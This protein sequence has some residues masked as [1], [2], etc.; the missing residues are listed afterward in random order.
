MIMATN[1]LFLNLFFQ[2][3]FRSLPG[4]VIIALTTM[5]LPMSIDVSEVFLCK[6]LF[7]AHFK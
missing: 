6:H 7:H 1:F 4:F 3:L 5:R 2:T